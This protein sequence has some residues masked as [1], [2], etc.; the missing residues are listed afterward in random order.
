M[1]R[2]NYSVNKQEYLCPICQRLS[3]SVL[4]IAPPLTKYIPSKPPSRKTF[5]QWFKELIEI[6][7]NKTELRK[8]NRISDDSE[9][10]T[11]I[12]L[13]EPLNVDC[14]LD[15]NFAEMTTNFAVNC[16][17]VSLFSTA[18]FSSK[19]LKDAFLLFFLAW[20]QV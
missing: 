6:V 10:I 2:S 17:T 20:N 8:P 5:P 9:E 14:I 19:G 15:D 7:I 11:N 13:R 18:S 1:L 12:V 4:P 16:V 3:N